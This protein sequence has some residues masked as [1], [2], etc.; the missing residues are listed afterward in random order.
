MAK[1]VP[2]MIP[3]MVPKM[4][5]KYPH[6]R[7]SSCHL[8]PNQEVEINVPALFHL[9]GYLGSIFGTIFGI[10]FG[11]ICAIIRS[12]IFGAFLVLFEHKLN[13]T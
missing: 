1:M 4:G 12:I 8:S 11:T 5:L 2:K 9:L 6:K 3:K 7:K 10:I 13:P